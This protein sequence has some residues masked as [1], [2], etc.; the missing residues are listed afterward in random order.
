[1]FD[2]IKSL[3]FE[4]R[5]SRQTF[6]K[7]VFWLTV[8]NVVNRLIRAVLII[9]AARVL[10]VA[11]YGIFS[12]AVGLA[13]FFSIFS[14]VGVTAVITREGSKN[15][16]SL[17]KYFTTALTIKVSLIAL[18]AAL[19]VFVS[20]F[21][22]NIKEALPLLPIAALLIT[23]DSLRDISFSLTRAWEKM[24]L[25][26]IIGLVTNTAIT[27]LG[28]IALLLHPTAKVFLFGYS[29]G[30]GVGLIYA[31]YVL[32]NSFPHFWG[33]FDFSIAKEIL[34]EALPLAIMGLMGSLMISTDTIILGFFKNATDLGLY[35]AAQRPVMILY[36]LP[37]ILS[38]AIFPG[39][40]RL[41]Q[42]N[43]E[44]FRA[45]LET[46][47]IAT[48]IISLPLFLGGVI[49]AP[50]MIGILFGSEYSGAVLTYGIL[51]FTLILIFPENFLTNSIFALGGQK[52]F[53]KFALIGVLGNALLDILLIP[54]FGIAGSAVATVI[55]GIIITVLLWKTANKLSP[56]KIFN[57]LSKIFSAV[58][59]MS[60]AT[61]LL[62]W[63]G[64]PFLVN[65]PLSA[66]LYSLTLYWF[67]E[68]V[69]EEFLIPLKRLRTKNAE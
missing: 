55:T 37:S 61:A 42:N 62:K 63:I 68:P 39:M 5:S 29:L 30:S 64:T 56:F 19:I 21:F 32:R 65:I 22:T 48:F 18:S 27:V 36:A 50:D 12:Y 31:I 51:L 16:G 46:S 60:V 45:V 11:G 33:R 14:D 44:R 8:A 1:M 20:P 23:F 54:K 41:A 17:K 4:N 53:L 34:T 25:E 52:S 3:L 38:T 69:L 7:N 2:R 67:K 6:T 57:R 58:I 40:T 9:Y 28:I 24:E 13:A 26:A 47:L 66:I 59:I 43:I 15:T 10:G 35:S 49:L